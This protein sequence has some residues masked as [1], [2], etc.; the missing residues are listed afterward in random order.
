MQSNSRYRDS[1]DKPQL[2][3]NWVDV[4]KI[5][6]SAYGRDYVITESVN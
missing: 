3:V 5:A 4:D 1:P 2:G 6:L